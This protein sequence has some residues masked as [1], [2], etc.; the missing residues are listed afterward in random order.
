M[1]SQLD[2]SRGWSYPAPAE[3]SA[4]P[5][6]LADLASSWMAYSGQELGR[7]VHQPLLRRLVEVAFQASLQSDEGRPVRLQ[8]HFTLHQARPTIGFEQPLPFDYQTLVKLAPTSDIGFRWLVVA[9]AAGDDVPVILGIHD[10]EL[11]PGAAGSEGGAEP[12]GERSL[13]LSVF[14]PGWVRLE[15]AGN[16]Y[17][18]LRNAAL[19]TI[20]PVNFIRRVAEWYDEAATALA[21]ETKSDPARTREL[22]ARV[23]VTI[24]SQVCV[25]PYG[26]VFLVIPSETPLDELL[27]IKYRVESNALRE[28]IG[29][30]AGAGEVPTTAGAKDWRALARRGYLYLLDRSV[31]R[32]ADFVAMLAAV[33]GAVVLR[34]DLSLV[35]FGAEITQTQSAAVDERVEFGRHPHGKPPSRR[36][37]DF[38]MR[39]RSAYRFCQRVESAIAFVIS[40]D[41]E[42]R[43]FCNTSKGVRLFEGVTPEEEWII[44]SSVGKSVL[45]DA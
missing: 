2:I 7:L 24:L 5:G 34:R 37:T 30:R 19:R 18:E 36:L 41:G 22:L 31:G 13:Q 21:A 38:G 14:G 6:H 29:V 44:P 16:F 15:T 26:G 12:S 9:P 1:A 33:D 25:E 3:G 11:S 23:W 45:A 40:Q 8:V 42:L 35:G 28:M 27:K 17:C 43:V 20:L 10:P 32:L 39:H 4:T